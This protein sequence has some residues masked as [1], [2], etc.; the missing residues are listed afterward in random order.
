MRSLCAEPR[1]KSLAVDVSQT[2]DGASYLARI[3][4]GESA[5]SCWELLWLILTP[6]SPADSCGAALALSPT[7]AALVD[8][9]AVDAVTQHA[10][11]PR[12]TQRD[13]GGAALVVVAADAVRVQVADEH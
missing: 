11:A 12:L 2:R 6:L 4:R 3:S 9:A 5:E 7:Q 13:A 8:Q 1:F 10:H